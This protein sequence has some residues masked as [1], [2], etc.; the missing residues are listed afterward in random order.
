MENLNIEG[1]KKQINIEKFLFLKKEE[2]LH[3]KAFFGRTS[4]K[5]GVLICSIVSLILLTWLER[6][7]ISPLNGVENVQSEMTSSFVKSFI[8]VVS[9]FFQKSVC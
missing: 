4:L 1:I 2:N 9:R 7:L 6:N 3:V 5:A 8:F